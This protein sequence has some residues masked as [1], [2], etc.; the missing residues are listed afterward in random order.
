MVAILTIALVMSV[1]DDSVAPV[2]TSVPPAGEVVAYYENE[3]QHYAIEML[4]EQDS[5]E[6]WTCLYTLWTRESNWRPKAHNKSSGAY[7]IAQFMPRTWITLGVKKT[8]DGFKQVEAGLA[9]IDR[10]WGGNICKALSHS[11][12]KGY[13]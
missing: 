2:R 11:L 9:Y 7:G 3:Y 5:I 1:H 4:I 10:R 8:D 12:A 6:Q 13:Y